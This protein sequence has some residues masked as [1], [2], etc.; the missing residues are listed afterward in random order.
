MY[1]NCCLLTVAS[2]PSPVIN[3]QNDQGETA[4]WLTS[5]FIS[6]HFPNMVQAAAE[7]L[8]AGADPNISSNALSTF[9]AR[10]PLQMAVQNNNIS[11]CRLLLVAGAQ[12]SLMEQTVK[13]RIWLESIYMKCRR[14]RLL[15][16]Y[17]NV[18]FVALAGHANKQNL[19]KMTFG[20]LDFS[21]NCE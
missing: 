16:R 17:K 18:D 20:D 14:K 3:A 10:T 9:G 11:I 12:P 13:G 2:S 7:L 19:I 15:R 1:N 6:A 4:L 21:T 8:N 5:S